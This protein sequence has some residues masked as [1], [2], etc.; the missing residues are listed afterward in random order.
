MRVS[1]VLEFLTDTGYQ[2]ESMKVF[3]NNQEQLMGYKISIDDWIIY[4]IDN[5]G[6]V[7][8]L[9]SVKNKEFS[10]NYIFEPKS[11]RHHSSMQSAFDR[12]KEPEED[13]LR[14]ACFSMFG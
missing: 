5:N 6:Q 13:D 4:F 1:Q 8:C 9:Q 3:L 12:V 2:V 14:M 7:N 11:L 10:F